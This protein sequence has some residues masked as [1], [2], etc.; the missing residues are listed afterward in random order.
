MVHHVVSNVSLEFRCSN[1]YATCTLAEFSL[2]SAR[3]Q[4]LARWA[5]VGFMLSGQLR[6]RLNKFAN[7]FHMIIYMHR[8]SM[9]VAIVFEQPID[10][11]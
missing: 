4:R 9:H 2:T 5:R 6:P 1:I 3:P 10:N 7:W 8:P 11:I